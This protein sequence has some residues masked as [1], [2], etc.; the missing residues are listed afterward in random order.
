[1]IVLVVGP[2]QFPD[3]LP[4]RVAWTLGVEPD[5]ILA[6]ASAEHDH[7]VVGASPSGTFAVPCSAAGAADLLRQFAASG[8]L[9]PSELIPPPASVAA[10]MSTH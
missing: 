4:R 10:L 5:V 2:S 9:D 1:V 3:D 8:K 6:N 7:L